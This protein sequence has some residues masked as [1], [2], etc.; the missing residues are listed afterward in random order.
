MSIENRIGDLRLNI[1]YYIIT[2]E[3]SERITG[4]DKNYTECNNIIIRIIIIGIYTANS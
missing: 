4:S 2:A 3:G 1:N